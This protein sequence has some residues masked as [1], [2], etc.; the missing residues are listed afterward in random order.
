MLPKIMV[1][2]YVENFFAYIQNLLLLLKLK[3]N[4]LLCNCTMRV[5]RLTENKPI[6]N[7]FSK[8]RQKEKL[9][10]L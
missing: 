4:L 9:F 6:Y 2:I 5:F 10:F 3:I 7:C 8:C 1:Q